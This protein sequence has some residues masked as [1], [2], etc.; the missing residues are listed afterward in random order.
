MQLNNS[1]EDLLLPLATNTIGPNVEMHLF[2]RKLGIENCY[3]EGN[4]TVHEG[5]IWR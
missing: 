5:H 1:S 2:L 3:V 4:T